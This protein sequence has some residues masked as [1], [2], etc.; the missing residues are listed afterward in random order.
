M[1]AAAACSRP[2]TALSVI[3]AATPDEMVDLGG[4]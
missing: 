3:G 2:E 4:G 1:P